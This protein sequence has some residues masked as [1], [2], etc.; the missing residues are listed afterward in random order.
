MPTNIDEDT[1]LDREWNEKNGGYFLDKIKPSDMIKYGFQ[2]RDLLPYIYPT[3][4]EIRKV[5]V[6][7]VFLG[8]Y[9]KWDIFKQLE[10]VKRSRIYRKFR[11]NRRDISINGKI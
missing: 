2:K 4:E 7:G 6:T 1:I 8:S 9:I 11:T 10:L 3:D 5:G